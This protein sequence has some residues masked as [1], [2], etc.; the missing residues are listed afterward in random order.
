MRNQ[1][2]IFKKINELVNVVNQVNRELK[3]IEEDDA[4]IHDITLDSSY[5]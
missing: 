2:K 1:D 4:K 3:K 5:D